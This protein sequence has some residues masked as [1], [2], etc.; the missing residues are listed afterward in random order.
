MGLFK[1]NV[2]KEEVNNND[3][4]NEVEIVDLSSDTEIVNTLET[5]KEKKVL[6]IILASI[7][8]AGLLLPTISN[9]FKAPNK[10]VTIDN[11]V[12]DDVVYNDTFNNKLEIN[13]SKG[14]IILKDIKFYS[15]AKKSNNV[16]T[17]SYLPNK[18]INNI[19]DENIFIELYNKNEVVIYREKF[20]S[21]NKL[22]KKNVGVISL[23]VDEEVYKEVVYGSVKV[24]NSEEFNKVTDILVCSLKQVKD[25]YNYRE[26]RTFNFSDN[27]LVSYEINKFV[28]KFVNDEIE[29]PTEDNTELEDGMN[30]S[31]A[32][33]SI[34]NQVNYEESF[35]KEAEILSKEGAL[36]LAYD[37]TMLKYKIDLLTFKSDEIEVLYNVST[38]KRQIKYLLEKESWDCY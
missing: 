25:D 33:E 24:I 36:E 4:N 31:T 27:G 5:R 21:K 35:K 28:E 38:T 9:L 37:S 15:F 6:I 18:E 11:P 20:V 17:L 19:E 26:K 32:D 14:N 3:I 16:I 2:T 23:N 8:L 1:K 22:I 34:N 29:V 10:N 12:T 13:K 30:E 7:L